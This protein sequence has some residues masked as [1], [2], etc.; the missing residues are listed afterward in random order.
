[1][2]AMTRAP[3]ISLVALRQA[4]R[5]RRCVVATESGGHLAYPAYWRQ[6]TYQNAEY[7]NQEHLCTLIP[8]S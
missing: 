1:M 3:H 6:H 8:A 2:A 5:Y 4:L 7:R